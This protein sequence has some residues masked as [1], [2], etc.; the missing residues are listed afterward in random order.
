MFVLPVLVAYTVVKLLNVIH[1]TP[2][3]FIDKNEGGWGRVNTFLLT[4]TGLDQLHAERAPETAE[5]VIQLSAVLKKADEVRNE[6]CQ[7]AHNIDCA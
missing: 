5:N 2:K 4:E 7:I 6:V 1:M 3:E